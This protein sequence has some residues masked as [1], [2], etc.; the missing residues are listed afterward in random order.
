MLD[1]SSHTVATASIAVSRLEFRWSETDSFFMRV[2]EFRLA[3][4]ERLLLHGE[5]GAGKSTFLSLICGLRRPQR[6]SIR[7]LDQ[8]LTAMP[9]TR[10]DRFRSQNFGIIFQ[11]FNL[12]PYLDAIDNVLLPLRLS[13]ERRAVFDG[14]SEARSEAMRLLERL[15]IEAPDRSRPARK[16]SVGQQQRV[17]AARA[18][19]GAPPLVIAD[20]PTSALD[21]AAGE[22]FLELLLDQVAEATS[23]LILVSHDKRLRPLFGRSVSLT[24]LATQGA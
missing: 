11:M 21:D 8:D 1:T 6:G 3:E 14:W 2:D 20:E 19:I 10:R 24:E 5:S 15:G 18:L 12:I 7:V 17:A 4:G 16:L 9:P 23:S 22:R 13:A